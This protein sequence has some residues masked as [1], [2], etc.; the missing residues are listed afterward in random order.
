M[1]YAA[2]FSTGTLLTADLACKKVIYFI[3]FEKVIILYI[4]RQ[5]PKSQ[6]IC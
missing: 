1:Y 4:I 6:H 5:F 2:K 3:E